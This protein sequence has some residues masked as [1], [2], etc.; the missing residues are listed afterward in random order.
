M[1]SAASIFQIDSSQLD[2]NIDY[3][4]FNE[5]T[6]KYFNNDNNDGETKTL[7]KEK[8][9]EI[10]QILNN[11]NKKN[12]LDIIHFNDVYNLEP[13]YSEDPI[14]GVSRFNTALTNLKKE[15][16]SQ[17]RKPIIIFS[18]DFVGPS[19]MSTITQGAHIID[20]FNL[21]GVDYGN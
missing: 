20:A 3:N 2:D 1:G 6:S 10:I 17:G 16:A 4:K 14:G 13:Q 9:L 15:L 12:I 5:L 18:G 7:S 11:N 21:I 19:L 8:A